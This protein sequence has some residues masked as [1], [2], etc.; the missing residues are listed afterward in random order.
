[1][2]ID[3]PPFF[4]IGKTVL[5]LAA[6][7][8]ICG[9]GLF[10]PGGARGEVAVIGIDAAR[11]EDLMPAVEMLLSDTGKASFDRRT[12]S[13]VV[14]DRPAV[15]DNI[16]TLLKKLDRPAR[17]LTIRVRFDETARDADRNV[18][19]RGRWSTGTPNGGSNRVDIALG[20]SRRSRS[21]TTEQVIRVLSGSAA[22][23]TVGRDIPFT[24]KWSD[25]CR[26]FSGGPAFTGFRR[27]E[28]G[29]E[30]VPRFQDRGVLL[31]ITPRLGAMAN[32]PG[33]SARLVQAAT[34]ILA[35]PGRWIDLGRIA[36]AGNEAFTRILGRGDSGSQE[37]TQIW[38]KVETGP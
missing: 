11:P 29:F 17:Q 33:G 25:L 38:L 35:E 6:L 27:I 12:H 7:M 37:T 30:V 32:G 31:R 2:S 15:V 9:A 4:S 21:S 19:A 5:V 14:V 1:M 3:S 18:S 16:R 8:V 22:V 36:V 10:H 23:I 20:G 24:R 13:L 34:E 26:R 28:T